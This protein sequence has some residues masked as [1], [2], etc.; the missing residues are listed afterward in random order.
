MI[1]NLIN[2]KTLE[3]C[4]EDNFIGNSL[5]NLNKLER[6]FII[7]CTNLKGEYLTYVDNNTLKLLNLVGLNINGK[8][9]L[10]LTNL[11]S[12]RIDRISEIYDNDLTHFTNLEYFVSDLNINGSCLKYFTKLKKLWLINSFVKDE[13]LRECKDLEYFEIKNFSQLEGDFLNYLKNLRFINIGDYNM[14]QDETFNEFKSRVMND[15]TD[16]Y[17]N[18]NLK[19]KKKKKQITFH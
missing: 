12:L 6:L 13:D 11:I 3:L 14:Q 4:G 19:D 10:H 8:Y 17:G 18:N 5:Q 2:L 1:K 7:N 9:L 16:N 15:V